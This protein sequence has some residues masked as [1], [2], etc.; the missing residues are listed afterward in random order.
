M[1]LKHI[2]ETARQDTDGFSAANNAILAQVA[3]VRALLEKKDV[4]GALA[5]L[6]D[7]E[8]NSEEIVNAV[9]E[10]TPQADV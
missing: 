5:L 2:I 6:D 3:A 8:A 4:K 9:V 1:A 10:N 7:I